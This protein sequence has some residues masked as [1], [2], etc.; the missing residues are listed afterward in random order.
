[1]R[2]QA[3]AESFTQVV[4]GSSHTCAL[5]S[6]GSAYCWGANGEGQL[7]DGTRLVRF[8][9]VAV[10]QPAAF[11]SLTAGT[12]HTC[13]LTAGGVAYCWGSNVD[14]QLGDGTTATR[15]VPNE[16]A[17]GS[18][19]ASLTAGPDHTCGLTDEQRALCWGNDDIG[20]VGAIGASHGLPQPVHHD[21]LPREW[22]LHPAERGPAVHVR[23]RAATDRPG[24]GAV[25]WQS[26]PR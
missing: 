8:T 22:R 20:Q 16:V 1:M 17:G 18:R 2:V 15:L 10:D 7:G 23:R 21:A 19:F 14:G 24:A 13:G 11:V 25:I 5:T 4:A 9:P 26:A 12:A 3:G 6:T